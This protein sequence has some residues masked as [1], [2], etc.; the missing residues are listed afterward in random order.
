V[1]LTSYFISLWEWRSLGK[2]KKNVFGCF[3]KLLFLFH[4]SSPFFCFLLFI[5][6]VLKKEV[7]IED[8]DVD[9]TMVERRILALAGGSPFLTNLFATFQTPD[10]LFFV[11]EFVNGGDLVSFLF[12]L[13]V[14]SVT[15]FFFSFAFLSFF[16]LFFSC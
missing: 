12:L 1:E 4:P 2:K 10:R 5:S 16:L 3:G 6:Q 9:C 13:F 11:M 15:V 14:Y 8:D 7:V